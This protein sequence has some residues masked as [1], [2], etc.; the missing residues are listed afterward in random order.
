[1]LKYKG[2]SGIVEYDDEGRIFTGEVIGLRSMITFQG[3]TPEEIEE[4]F[5]RSID[6]YLEMCVDDG[7]APEKPYSGRFNIRIPP[8]LHREIVNRAAI[9]QRS[10]NDWVKEA[11][12][13]SV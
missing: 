7:V 8:E 12:E 11:L 5:R 10:L 13:K 3:R 6:L 9:E 1:M 4:L 2:Y